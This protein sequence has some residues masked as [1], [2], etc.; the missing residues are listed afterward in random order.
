MIRSD[1]AHTRDGAHR[2]RRPAVAWAQSSPIPDTPVPG[3]GGSDIRAGHRGR[4]PGQQRQRRRLE[5]RRRRHGVAGRQRPGG[6][7]RPTARGQP[8]DQPV[9]LGASR[10]L[11]LAKPAR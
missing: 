10:D 2:S 8:G 11:P 3:F 5:R 9:M 1:F 6:A 7:G 4:Q